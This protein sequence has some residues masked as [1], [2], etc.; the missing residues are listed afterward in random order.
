MRTVRMMIFVLGIL[1][2]QIGSY[3]SAQPV[4]CL[5]GPGQVPSP[6]S[7]AVTPPSPL[8]ATTGQSPPTEDLKKWNMK[9]LEGCSKFK[10]LINSAN[11]K[12]LGFDKVEDAS[13]V[14]IGKPID[15]YT[16]GLTRI[17]EYKPG[18]KVAPLISQLESRLYPLSVAGQVRSSLVVSRV[19]E[20][21]DFTTTAYGLQQLITLVM[22]HKKSDSDFVVW[23][24]VLNLHFLGDHPDE[25]LKLTPLA[26]RQLY[27]LTEGVPVEAAVVFALLAQQA[28]AHDEH[29]PG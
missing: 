17:R 20:T 13:N 27:G 1:M 25:T 9:A 24:P 21:Q 14:H 23:F 28:R 15:I 4:P 19:M 26:T 7:T 18:D 2:G 11:S 22:R 10:S 12:L 16:I 6:G 3:A 29:N 8:T 5:P